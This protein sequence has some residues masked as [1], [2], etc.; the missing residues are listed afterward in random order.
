MKTNSERLHAAFKQADDGHWVN[1]TEYDLGL[2]GSWER[3]VI[4]GAIDTHLAPLSSVIKQRPATAM[5]L[6]TA[7]AEGTTDDGREFEIS[8]SGVTL[9]LS[10]G[11]FGDTREVYTIDV[12]DLA[13]A[14]LRT[15]GAGS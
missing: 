8:S 13:P 15:V 9:I 4:D 11:P 2:D 12:R 14:W 5:Y 7:W 1:L 10:I 6:R 3:E